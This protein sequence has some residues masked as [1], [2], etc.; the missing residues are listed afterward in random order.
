M[1]IQSSFPKVADQVITFNKNIIDILSKINSLTTTTDSSVDLQIFDEEGVL[2]NYSLPSFASLKAEIDRLNNNINSLFNIDSVGS[3]I[4]TSNENKY[5][6]IISVNLNR[7]PLAI[8]SLGAISGFS[9]KVNWFFD[10]LV[11]PML[12]VNID[13]SDKIE[14]NVRKCLVRRYIVDF[15]SSNGVLTNSGQSALNAFNEQFRGNSNILSK[16]FEEWHRTTPGVLEPDNIKYDEDTFELEPNSI[17]YDGEFSVLKIQEDRLNKKL[18]YVLNTLDFIISSTGEVKSLSIGNELI[19]NSDSTSTRYKVI[20]VSLSQSNPRVRL[21]RLEGIE[22]IAVGI[23][24]LKI[25]SPV[26]YSKNIKVSIGYDERNV[27]FIKPINT[28]NNIV[29]KKWS[30]GTGFYTNDLRHESNNSD[31]GL[32]MEQ[33]YSENVYDYGLALKDL[34]SKK[35]PNKLAVVP[36]EPILSKENFRVVQINKHLTDNTDTKLIKQKHNYQQTLKSEIKQLE[37]AIIDKDKSLKVTKFKSESDRKKYS[38]EIEELI[39]K[40]ESKNKL[41]TSTTQEI[42]SLSKGPVSKVSPKFRLR[43]FWDIPDPM[44]SKGTAPQEIIQFKIQYRYVSLDGRQTPIEQFSLSDKSKESSLFSNWTESK[45]DVRKR[46][47]DSET[48]EYHWESENTE[49]SDT[50]NINQLDIPIQNGERVEFRIKSISEAGWPESPVESDWTESLFIDFPSDL[51][52]ISNES[53]LILQDATKEDILISINS[54]LEAKGLTEH[55]SDTLVINSKVFHHDASKI[56]SGITD[57]NGIML[58]LFEYLS[59]LENKIRGLEE[60]ISRSRGILK[61]VILRNNEEF[62]VENDSET[63]F[64]IE[65]EDHLSEFSGTGIPTGRVY[66]NSIYV[67]KDFV[68]KVTNVAQ[69]SILGLLSN[70]NYLQNSFAYNANAPQVFWINDQDELLK[71]DISAQTRTQLNNQFIWSVN[72]DSVTQNTVS[73]LSENTGNQF[74]TI[75]NNSITNILSSPQYNIGYNETSIL[76]FVGNNTSLLDPSKWIDKSISAAST[77]KL[78]TSIHPVVKDLEKNTEINTEKIKS[79]K[80][81]ENSSIIIPL[82]IYFKMNA[83]DTNQS[84]L[85]YSY[86]NMNNSTE[87]QQHIKKVKFMLENE[88]DNRPFV[89]TIKFNINRNKVKLNKNLQASNNNITIT[90]TAPV[91]PSSSTPRSGSGSGTRRIDKG[92]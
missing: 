27:I 80:S 31:N 88:S 82:N 92:F 4:Q 43:G 17:L 16:E 60:R 11:D 14:R 47:Y 66:E 56:S 1:K 36:S 53:E 74:N 75:N 5:K 85:N 76:S 8:N 21:E 23:N 30:L 40:K 12:L 10:G 45:T 46:I 3:L 34:V 58:D 52:T 64:N 13:L 7:E 2:R 62:Y 24:T 83:L 57:D 68:I 91:I 41:I 15:D 26:I 55:L 69:E 42:L 25:Y 59:Y 37:D 71:S 90:N 78:L 28:E 86:I 63:T 44:N 49:S 20:E 72:Y 77:N 6:R 73:R 61:V 50:P 22:P 9:S 54:D 79:V 48:E 70:R 67:I 84:G 19:I 35:I 81:G 39:N 29:A 18:W 38:L 87:T 89:F 51:N 65:C 33:F 32:T